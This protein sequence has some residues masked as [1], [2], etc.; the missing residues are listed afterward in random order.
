M[1][2]E[3]FQTLDLNRFGRGLAK[4]HETVGSGRGRVEVTQPDCDDACVLISKAELESL[5]RA[6]QLFSETAEFQQCCRLIEQVVAACGVGP[7][8]PRFSANP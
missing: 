7:G 6:L 1:S 2:P 3:P 4:I 8:G 5:E